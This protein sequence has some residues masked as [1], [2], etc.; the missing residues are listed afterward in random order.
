VTK[1]RGFSLQ[2]SE[3]LENWVRQ[4]GLSVGLPEAEVVGPTSRDIITICAHI[5]QELRDGLDSPQRVLGKPGDVFWLTPYS[6]TIAKLVNE[7]AN[8]RP[9]A[10][11]ANGLRSM[12]GLCRRKAGE[13]AVG[14]V[15]R[16]SLDQL[17]AS[18]EG[19]PTA[20]TVIEARSYERFRHWPQVG[21]VDSQ[22]V[23][24]TYELSAYARATSD[25]GLH[26]VPE[27]ISMPLQAGKLSQVVYVGPI[28]V[29]GYGATADDGEVV[30]PD[31]GADEA[32]AQEL[33]PDKD[34]PALLT[35][36]GERLAL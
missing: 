26:G 36:L 1:E 35:W 14:I 21:L 29:S 30:Y 5:A 10:E 16:L 24:R 27:V 18:P 31:P 17:R 11:L 34:G 28:T 13:H 19:P 6:D 15:T 8:G 2:A 22:H 7:A 3:A 4:S 23:G 32:F 20:P 33:S 25:R 12:L 9:A